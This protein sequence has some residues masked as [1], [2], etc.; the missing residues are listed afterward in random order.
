M[1]VAAR[2]DRELNQL[3]ATGGDNGGEIWTL[4]DIDLE[5]VGKLTDFGFH[6]IEKSAQRRLAHA[7]LRSR[8][9]HQLADD[10][11]R[12]EIDAG[13]L[14]VKAQQPGPVTDHLR[15]PASPSRLCGEG[16]PVGPS[17]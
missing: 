16:L 10:L 15:L 2:L 3:I 11:R 13:D 5:N 14:V 8:Q 4:A 6:V 17:P 1:G 7:E 12:A 9:L